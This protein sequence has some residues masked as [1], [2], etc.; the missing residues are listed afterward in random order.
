LRIVVISDTHG[1]IEGINKVIEQQRK[2]D[3]FIFLGDC[4]R[5]IENA[6]S[7]FPGKQFLIVA[8]NCDFGSDSP[9]EGETVIAGRRIFY[10]HGHIYQV[11]FGPSNIIHEARRRKADILLYGHTHVAYTTYEDGLYIMNPG[12]IGHPADGRPTYGIVDITDA[13]IVTNVVEV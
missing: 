7:V 6:E 11:K 13:G 8:G 4:E 1:D 2:A 10:T 5:D 3:L 9:T 12:S